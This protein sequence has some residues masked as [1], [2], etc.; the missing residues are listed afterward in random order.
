MVDTLETAAAFGLSVKP[1]VAMGTGLAASI[2][3]DP[4]RAEL[5]RI[6]HA[7]LPLTFAVNSINRSMGLSDLY[8]F[9]LAPAVIVKLAFVHRVI[10]MRRRPEAGDRSASTIRAIVAGIR[11]TVGSPEG[12]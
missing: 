6:I 1:R 8:P 5:E 11:R 3:F 4:H 7:W 10:E 2:D 12:W 9:V